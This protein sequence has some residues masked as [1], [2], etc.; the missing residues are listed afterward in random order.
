MASPVEITEISQG[1]D[2]VADE[3]FERTATRVFRVRYNVATPGPAQAILDQLIRRYD[4]YA[5]PGGFVDDAM[6]ATKASSSPEDGESNFN[7]LVTVNYSTRWWDEV[8]R[9][10]HSGGVGNTGPRPGG[11][12]GQ[13]D[14]VSPA[15]PL[16]RPPRYRWGF[17]TLRALMERDRDPTYNGGNGRAI[18]LT[19][20]RPL[21]PPLETDRKLLTCTVDRNT[22]VFSSSLAEQTIDHVN[23]QL[24]TLAGRD[25]VAGVVKCDVW[26]AESQEP[27]NSIL[28]WAERIVFIIN[29][30]FTIPHSDI[31][32]GT[33]QES[34]WLR[35]IL[36]ADTCELTN[37]SGVVTP[38][39]KKGER[40]DK[41]WPLNSQG[42]KL[43][44]N[45]TEDDLY[46]RAYVEFPPADFSVFGPL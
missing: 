45:H 30:G 38:I 35:V 27:E 33:D 3:R 16:A 10:E 15:N 32:S 41:P 1:R 8:A 44:D 29:R 46:Y 11:G 4:R 5:E 7:H 12:G 24:F 23:S 34:K 36:Q 42:A 40:V 19:N 25:F 6:L 26:E 43:P 21:D 18:R 9:N 28:Y 14:A 37:G 2:A 13:P 31:G 17:T 39:M 20:K 22:P